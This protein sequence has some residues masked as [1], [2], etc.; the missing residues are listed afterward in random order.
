MRAV[1]YHGAKSRF[2]L[3]CKYF[4]LLPAQLQ[5]IKTNS[6]IDLNEDAPKTLSAS[7]ESNT[8]CPAC[9][10]PMRLKSDGKIIKTDVEVCDDCDGI[11]LSKAALIRIE[12]DSG[13]VQRNRDKS[14]GRRMT[15]PKCGLEQ[16]TAE[17]C[18]RCQVV[19]AKFQQAQQETPTQYKKLGFFEKIGKQLEARIERSRRNRKDYQSSTRKF[20]DACQRN[21]FASFLIRLTNWTMVLVCFYLAGLA[22]IYIFSNVTLPPPRPQE[23]DLAEA[24]VS[25]FYIFAIAMA[26]PAMLV[27][28]VVLWSLFWY[29]LYGPIQALTHRFFHPIIKPAIA[30]CLMLLVLQSISLFANG[31]WTTYWWLDQQVEQA[32]RKA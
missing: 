27:I 23:F 11:W 24:R 10:G 5:E 17:S 12:H 16:Q 21:R 19:V 28:T 20:F 6:N 29:G 25:I 1:I 9:D 2:C 14:S 22:V 3:S 18:R 8:R 30:I 26:G 4:F 7:G 13:L 31:F 15:C 32:K